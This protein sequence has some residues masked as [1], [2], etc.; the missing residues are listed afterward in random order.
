MTTL[1]DTQVITASGGL[2]ELGFQTTDRT[3]LAVSGTSTSNAVELVT[4]TVVCDGSPITVEFQC[5]MSVTNGEYLSFGVWV[6]GTYTTTFEGSMAVAGR[7][8][9]SAWAR[10]TPSAGSR[11]ISIRWWKWSGG[12]S[13]S[14]IEGN[15]R[16]R[17]S[18]IV[19]ATQW[20]AV[21]TGTI[22]C[23][24]STRPSAPFEGQQIWE[25]DTDLT[26]IWSGA[27]W[28]QVRRTNDSVSTSLLT[29]TVANA[30]LPDGAPVWMTN[31]R[32]AFPA[33]SGQTAN[34]SVTVPYKSELMIMASAS[35]FGGTGLART[36]TAVYGVTG[37]VEGS[38][39]YFNVGGDHRTTPTAVHGITL[40]AGTYTIGCL[41]NFSTDSN[42]QATFMIVGRKVT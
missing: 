20:P 1:T 17:V 33:G 25:A 26:Y 34:I 36:Y 22:I 42:D 3:N 23:T 5:G 15:C 39:Y 40:N 6:D 2:V 31:G 30:N 8:P 21:T 11:I 19:Q 10:L 16:V 13:T 14:Y 29:G 12:T 37:W 35:A 38:Y 32:A 18:K 9:I 28:L 4:T 7:A 41:Q 24:S 27:A